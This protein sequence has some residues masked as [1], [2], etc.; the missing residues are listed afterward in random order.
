[1][2]EGSGRGAEARPARTGVG[3]DRENH[4]I[5]GGVRRC[6]GI[7]ELL[8]QVGG[9]E[10]L[11]VAARGP[12]L[13]RVAGVVTFP[14][15]HAVRGHH[16]RVQEFGCGELPAGSVLFGDTGEGGIGGDLFIDVSDDDRDLAFRERL[17]RI[18]DV[19]GSEVV[20]LQV[21]FRLA[22]SK[23]TIEGHLELLAAFLSDLDVVSAS[24]VRSDVFDDAL[25]VREGQ[26]AGKRDSELAERRAR[27]LQ[28]DWLQL[29]AAI[30]TADLRLDLLLRPSERAPLGNSLLLLGGQ[31]CGPVFGGTGVRWCHAAP[32]HLCV[33]L[34][35]DRFSS[36][37][38]FIGGRF[39]R[40]LRRPAILIHIIHQLEGGDQ[41]CQ[42]CV[43]ARNGS[44]QLVMLFRREGRALFPGSQVLQGVSQSTEGL[45]DASH[46]VFHPGS[47]GVRVCGRGWSL[48]LCRDVRG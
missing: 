34:L 12:I 30:I 9:D 45:R 4:V 43:C 39:Q 22:T 7:E 1:M 21:P 17:V 38:S 41:S 37:P 26:R 35:R 11:D 16:V 33:G 29:E 44:L 48:L 19:E 18:T 15:I 13:R 46:G 14:A 6:L 5:Q 40:H 31:W 10:H 28:G 25:E 47:E 3:S 27:S 42:V 2:K 24:S 8:V 36:C 23:A 20:K 32:G